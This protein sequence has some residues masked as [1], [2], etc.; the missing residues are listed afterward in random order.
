MRLKHNN[1]EGIYKAG[2]KSHLVLCDLRQ[3]DVR[4]I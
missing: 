2:H 3:L 1:R 4:L